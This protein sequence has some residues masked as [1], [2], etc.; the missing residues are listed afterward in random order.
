MSLYE[1]GSLKMTEILFADTDYFIR[2]GTYREYVTE[3]S[4]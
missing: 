3:T 4:S 1:K 2:R